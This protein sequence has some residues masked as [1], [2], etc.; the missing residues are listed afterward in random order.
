M[1]EGPTVPV[2]PSFDT[3]TKTYRAG[4]H[5]AADR[6]SAAMSPNVITGTQGSLPAESALT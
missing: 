4:K 5:K 3:G 6:E 2:F 1:A